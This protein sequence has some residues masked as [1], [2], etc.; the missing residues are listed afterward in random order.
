[1]KTAIMIGNVDAY[2]ETP[3]AIHHR[4]IIVKTAPPTYKHLIFTNNWGNRAPSFR[5][6]GQDFT[7]K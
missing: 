7:V 5:G 4:N 6:A 3:F 2:Y 1:M